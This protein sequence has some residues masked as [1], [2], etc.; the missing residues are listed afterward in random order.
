MNELELE[1]R[2]ITY[3]YSQSFVWSSLFCMYCGHKGF[4]GRENHD[5][6]LDCSDPVYYCPHC[7]ENKIHDLYDPDT[8]LPLLNEGKAEWII[9][10][11]EYSKEVTKT[12]QAWAMDEALTK[13]L[14]ALNRSLARDLYGDGT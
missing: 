10:S 5:Y 3:S 14:Q 13:S 11:K 6:E 1:T 8:T 2:T 7:K 4:Y 12:K 9:D